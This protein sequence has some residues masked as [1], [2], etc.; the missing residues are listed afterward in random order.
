[1]NTKNCKKR[2][3]AKSTISSL[4]TDTAQYVWIMNQLFV[5]VVLFGFPIIIGGLVRDNRTVYGSVLNTM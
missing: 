5:T 1:M 2:R 4:T 3:T